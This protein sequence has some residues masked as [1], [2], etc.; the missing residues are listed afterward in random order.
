MFNQLNDIRK[1][2]PELK[3]VYILRKTET[4]GM[5]KFVADADS[6]YFL[7]FD[8]YFGGNKQVT[9]SDESAPTGIY[10]DLYFSYPKVFKYG[11][12]MPVIEDSMVVNQWGA[13]LTASAPIVDKNG[14]MV[15]LLFVDEW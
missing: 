8:G 15:A 10:F 14:H 13:G 11:E 6:N 1:K 4:E 7:H 12:Y 3:Y 2:N 5:W 9:E